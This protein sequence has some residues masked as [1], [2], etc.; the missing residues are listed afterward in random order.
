MSRRAW[1]IDGLD[2]VG[3]QVEYGD[4]RGR[5]GQTREPDLVEVVV[6][7]AAFVG[8]ER[9]P[10]GDELDV[11]RLAAEDGVELVVECIVSRVL[12]R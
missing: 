12:R 5:P 6:P 7:G 3:C 1:D 9:G 2:V 8:E 11:G 10:L 4:A